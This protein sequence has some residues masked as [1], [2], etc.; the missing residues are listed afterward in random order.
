MMTTSEMLRIAGEAALKYPQGHGWCWGRDGRGAWR[1][2]GKSH[3]AV[4]R[5]RRR[6]L[7][8]AIG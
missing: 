1:F 7:P 5:A 4:L 8:K 6:G 2:D 3:E